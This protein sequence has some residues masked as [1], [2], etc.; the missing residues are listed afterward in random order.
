VVAFVSWIVIVITGRQPR[1]LQDALRFCVA[2]TQR[3]SA[4]LLLL[5]EAFPLFSPDPTSSR[6]AAGE[7]AS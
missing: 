4:Y 6:R 3:A 7:R 5:T 2:Y 1:E